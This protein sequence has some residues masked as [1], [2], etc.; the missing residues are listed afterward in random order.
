M[1]LSYQQIRKY[2]SGKN[3]VSASVLYEIANCLSLAIS[4]FYDGLPQA[5]SELV[6][7]GLP[8]MN[9]RIA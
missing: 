7:G 1:D 2:E 3:R 6:H 5:G 8:E 4:H 9:E